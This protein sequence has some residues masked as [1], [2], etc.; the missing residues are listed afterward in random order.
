MKKFIRLIGLI[1][2]LFLCAP[3]Y[4]INIADPGADGILVWDD[5][6]SGTNEEQWAAIGTGLTF[7]GATI[8]VDTILQKYAGVDPSA[9]VLTVLGSATFATMLTNM[10]LS[11]TVAEINTPL[12][13]ASVTLTEFQELETIGATSISADDWTAVAALVGVNTGDN[14]EAETGDSATDFFDAGEIVDARVSDTL[15]ATTIVVADNEATNETNAVIFSSGGDIDGGSYQLESDGD[16]TYDPGTGTLSAT[17]FSGGGTG[18]TGVVLDTEI[19]TLAKLETVSNGGAYMS[20]LLAAT[21]EANF[22]SIVNLE[23]NT[24]FYAPGGTDVADADVA[25]DITVSNYVLTEA[26][27]TLAELETVSNGGAYMSDL[28]AAT[29]EANFKSIVNLEANTDFYGMSAADTAFEAELNNSAGLL[30]ALSDETGTGV[31]VFSTSPALVTPALGVIASGNGAAL[32]AINAATVT[33][34]DNE[35][36]SEHNLIPF[37]ADAGASTGPHGLEFDG[38]FYYDPSTGKLYV[39]NGLDVAP[40]AT[41]KATFEDSDGLGAD[42]YAASI[43][44]NMTTVTDGSEVSDVLIYYQDAGTKT[45]ALTIDGSDHT[46]DFGALGIQAPMEVTAADADGET[47]A[48]ADLNTVR[49]SSGAGDWDLP[50]DSCDAATGNWITVVA[51]AA[52]VASVTSLDTSDIFYLSDGTAIGPNEELDTDGTAFSSVTVLCVATNTWL[53]VGER[54]TTADGGAAD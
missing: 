15:T 51:N 28:L 16:F 26:I 44:V 40:S 30:A 10:G 53:V 52:H 45:V 47:I 37:A 24:D 4:A 25:D 35:S 19:N 48:T 18:I 2:T 13:G 12:D 22:K 23:P 8:S 14:T 41:P 50:A 36:T 29:S 43:E 54:G 33:I 17:Q 1:L 39:A 49:I 3:A 27:N 46:A 38:D 7:N 9:N 32:T 34:T 6:D 5:S 21:S 20:D 31:A 11:A 42:E